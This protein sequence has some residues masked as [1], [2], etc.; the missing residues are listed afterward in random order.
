LDLG[1]VVDSTNVNAIANAQK[2]AVDMFREAGETASVEER[3]GAY[4]RLVELYPD[5]EYAPQALFMVGFVESEEKR[6]YDQA[7]A[8]FKQLLEKYPNS[9]LAS[10]AQ[11]MIEN[12]RS[13]KTPEFELPGGMGKASEH[14]SPENQVTTP[15]TGKP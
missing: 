9:E 4:R 10:S 13:D 8:A 2:S 6:D 5:S 11:W 1:V 3:V 14:D 15:P 7:E 12:M